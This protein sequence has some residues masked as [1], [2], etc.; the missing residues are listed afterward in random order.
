MKFTCTKENLYNTLSL[1]SPL[2]GKQSNL[3]ILTNVLINVSDTKVDIIATNLEMA[4]RASM[5]A[6]VDMPGSFT[7][8]ARVLTDYVQLLKGAQVDIERVGNEL[9]LT[10]GKANTKIKGLPAEDFPVMPEIH[11]N[12]GYSI[13]ALTLRTAL[14]RTVVAA[15][16]NEIKPELAGVYLGFFQE[17]FQGLILAATDSYRLAESRV[18]VVQGDAAVACIVPARTIYEI[19]RLLTVSTKQADVPERHVRLSLDENQISVRF[20]D[21]EM[22]SRL[23][24]G[25]Y[26]DYAQVIP[27]NSKTRATIPVKELVDTIKAASLFT[28]S[29]VNAISFDLNVISGSLGVSSTSTQTGEHHTAIDVEIE[30]EENSILLNH[31]YVLDGLGHMETEDV[32]LGVNSSDTPALFTPKG[33]DAYLYIVMPIRK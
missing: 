30:G 32:V 28:M 15:S 1:V 3:P 16:K 31:R 21:F 22:T 7:I 27:E 17:R 2:A 24:E 23:I 6:K 8:P 18:P 19:I 25:S 33:E 11:E 12:T 26:P 29:G 10:C 4:L 9:S 13:D 20:S 14:S 5:R